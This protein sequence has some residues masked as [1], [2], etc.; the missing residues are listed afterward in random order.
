MTT[1][2]AYLLVKV[3]ADHDLTTV[4]VCDPK[5][6]LFREMERTL[7]SQCCQAVRVRVAK[8]V[9]IRPMVAG[10]GRRERCLATR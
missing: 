9:V 6:R 8:A 4:T 7:L 10:Q 1:S 3:S 5:G 2:N